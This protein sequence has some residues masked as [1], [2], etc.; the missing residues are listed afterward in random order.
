M[1][2]PIVLR[3]PLRIAPRKTQ[4]ELVKSD[5]SLLL[6][7]QDC[8]IGGEEKLRTFPAQQNG[9]GHVFLPLPLGKFPTLVLV[10]N[11]FPPV[12]HVDVM[13]L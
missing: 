12:A 11:W 9:E 8:P 5:F 1:G 13:T 10:V 4:P 3:L 2:A 6:L 7:E